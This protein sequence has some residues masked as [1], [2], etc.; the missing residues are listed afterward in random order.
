MLKTSVCDLLGVELPIFCAAMGG[1]ARA[2][3][4]AAVSEA[5]AMGSLSS[6]GFG[7]EGA[8]REIREAKRL[9]KKPFAVGV[10]IPMLHDG[11]FDAIVAERV[12]ACIF[13]WGDVAPFVAKC[14]DAEIKVIC[15]V[16]S[17]EEAVSA[18]RAGADAIVAQGFDAGGHVRG[19]VTTLAIVPAVRDAIGDVPLIAAGGIA[20]GRGLAAALALGADGAMF[21]TRFIASKES[22]A[23]PIYKQKILASHTGNTLHTTLFDVGWPDAPHRVL[24]NKTVAM[25]DK[26]GRPES[27][28]RPGEGEIIGHARRGGTDLPL[29]RYAV[30]SPSGAIEGDIEAM[31]LYAGESAGLVN[32]ILP[33]SEIVRRIVDEARAAARQVIKLD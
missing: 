2:E 13:F 10:L 3:L 30:Y 9:T 5:G 16:G 20:D 14:K 19:Q 28:K 15:Q 18:V 33:A 12:S 32:D 1:V 24:S 29:V 11:V 31:A 22:A 6:S 7:V 21:G 23:H 4:A 27:G 8:I 17:V 26:A 25:W